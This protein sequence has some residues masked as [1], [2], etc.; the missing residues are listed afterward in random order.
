VNRLVVGATAAVVLALAGCGSHSSGQTPAHAGIDTAVV[1][2]LGRV[3]VDDRGRTLYVFAPDARH[4]VTCTG[5]CAGSWPPV[6]STGTAK[7]GGGV[8]ASLL[9]ADPDPAG[10]SVVTYGGWPLYSYVADVAAGLATGQALDLNGGY[11]YA[12]APDGTPVVPPG[13]P[14]LPTS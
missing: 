4:H 9:G 2:N 10:G 3:L 1:G 12:M 13:S 7:A 8:T 5:A 11:W 14:P 6:F